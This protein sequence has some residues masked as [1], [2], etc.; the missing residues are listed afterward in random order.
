[1]ST[2]WTHVADAL[3]HRAPE[4]PDDVAEGIA[5]VLDVAGSWHAGE[6]N[7]D[8]AIRLAL[9]VPRAMGY[10]FRLARADARLPALKRLHAIDYGRRCRMTYTTFGWLPN[11]QYEQVQRHMASPYFDDLR[12]GE[13]PPR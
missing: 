9:S 10:A 11:S 2:V 3:P 4:I 7:T 5:F 6:I 1:M 12:F 13:R 8:E